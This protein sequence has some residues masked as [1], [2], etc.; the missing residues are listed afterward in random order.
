MRGSEGDAAGE[1]GGQAERTGGV[2]GRAQAQ[3]AVEGV[4]EDHE[5]AAQMGVPADGELAAA[6]A[7]G[8]AGAPVAAPL[9]LGRNF[10]CEELVA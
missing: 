7:E 8:M 3:C 9:R 1:D 5:E 2:R 4:D 6:G 10:A